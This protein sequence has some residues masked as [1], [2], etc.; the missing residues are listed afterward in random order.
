MIKQEIRN[1][2]S[3]EFS[4]RFLAKMHLERQDVSLCS[5]SVPLCI[6]VYEH[7]IYNNFSETDQI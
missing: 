7:T 4:D 2:S 6:N 1:K 3:D 5:H